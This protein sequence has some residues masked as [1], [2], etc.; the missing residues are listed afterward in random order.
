MPAPDIKYMGASDGVMATSAKDDFNRLLKVKMNEL[1]LS[2]RIE[3][4]SSDEPSGRL[5]AP[6]LQ[7]LISALTNDMNTSISQ[8][9]NYSDASVPSSCNR[10]IDCN[11]Q[12]CY[13][14]SNDQSPDFQKRYQ[15]SLD[16][17]IFLYCHYLFQ[18]F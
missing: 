18:S 14:F 7:E 15:V 2:D 17:R 16:S 8:S 4:T 10:N 6:V 1:G 9:S 12:S 3:F 5:T 11:D 13:I